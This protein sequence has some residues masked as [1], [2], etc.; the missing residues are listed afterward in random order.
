MDALPLIALAGAA[1]LFLSKKY[2][3]NLE[4]KVRKQLNY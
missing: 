4:A 1:F 2:V 3:N